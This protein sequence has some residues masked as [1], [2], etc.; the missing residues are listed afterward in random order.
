MHSK[1]NNEPWEYDGSFYGFLTLVYYAFAEKNFPEII[2]TSEIA[3][4]SLFQSRLIETDEKMAK[5]I[6]ARLLKRLRPENSDFILN[7]F[8][9]SLEEKDRCLLDAIEIA[10]NT[11][12]LLTN[13]LG[14][15]SIL[16]LQ[17]SLKALFSEVHLY[18]GFVRFEFIGELL[19]SKICPK[20]LSL[21]FL[22]P[23]FAERYPNQTI[24]IYDEKHHLLAIIE[25]GEISLIEN[26]EPPIFDT[27]DTELNIQQNWQSFLTA[28]TINERK[29]EKVQ[30][31][32]LP[33]RYRNNM[34]DFTSF[35]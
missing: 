13:H 32:H 16:A 14:H 27:L 30:L 10:L 26:S 34:V 12:D 4:E 18:T 11:K 7:G 28:I 19:F 5:K 23:H 17:N 21:P 1:K 29:N 31:S 6:Y 3:I 35:S 24:M 8:Y 9:C 33:K 20:H 15:P 25:H 22:C 2:L